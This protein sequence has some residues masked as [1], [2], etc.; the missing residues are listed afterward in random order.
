MYRECFIIVLGKTDSCEFYINLFY[1]FCQC[2]YALGSPLFAPPLWQFKEFF[3]V[4]RILTPF[5]DEFGTNSR[6][7]LLLLNVSKSRC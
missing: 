2:I 7:Y 4:H 6:N 1:K 3:H 5:L